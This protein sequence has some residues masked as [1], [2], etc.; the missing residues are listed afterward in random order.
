MQS[1]CL[2][3]LMFVVLVAFVNPSSHAWDDLVEFNEGTYKGELE[4]DHEEKVVRIRYKKRGSWGRSKIEGPFSIATPSQVDN[5]LDQIENFFERFVFPENVQGQILS[6]VHEFKFLGGGQCQALH[7]SLTSVDQHEA[8]SA[9]VE[10]VEKIRL[11]QNPGA[12]A[13]RSLLIQEFKVDLGKGM[14][15]TIQLRMA[16]DK[17]D[18]FL[19]FSF[20]KDQGDLAKYTWNQSE[21]KVLL[22][23]PQGQVVLELDMRS[24][25]PEGG[26]LVVR[27]PKE[28]GLE[29]VERSYFRLTQTPVKKGWEVYPYTTQHFGETVIRN[30]VALTSGTANHTPVI[31][32]NGSEVAFSRIDIQRIR[33]KFPFENLE[34]DEARALESFYNQCMGERLSFIFE[35][36]K[37]GQATDGSF[38]SEQQVICERK[39]QLETLNL[40]LQKEIVEKELKTEVKERSLEKLR[41]CLK[42]KELAF[43]EN[44]FFSYDFSKFNSLTSADFEEKKKECYSL[45]RVEVLKGRVYKSIVNN[46]LLKE[47]MGSERT[48]ELL[49]QSVSSKLDGSCFSVVKTEDLDSCLDYSKILIGENLFL[50][51]TSLHLSQ[52]YPEDRTTYGKKR[53]E[54]VQSFSSC[55]EGNETDAVTALRAGELVGERLARIRAKDIECAQ[56]ATLDLAASSSNELFTEA[57]GR[58]GLSK[59]DVASALDNKEL[60]DGAL[61]SF[62]ECLEQSISEEMELSS[63]I[64]NISFYQESCLTTG[65]RPF[66]N[67]VLSRRFDDLAQNFD[68]LGQDRDKEVLRQKAHRLIDR[69]LGSW[70]EVSQFL[71]VSESLERPFHSLVLSNHID[72]IEE[73]LDREDRREF[74]NILGTLLNDSSTRP[75]KLKLRRYFD[76]VLEKSE[77]G[78]RPQS[79]YL[80]VALNDLMKQ[81]HLKSFPIRTKRDIAS[82]VL[83]EADANSIAERVSEGTEKCWADYS[84]NRLT[85]FSQVYR[86]CEK[87]RQSKV[88]LEL[89]RRRMERHVATFFPLTSDKANKILTPVQY[90]ESCFSG[91]DPYKNKS[92]PEYEKLIEGCLRVAELDISYNISNAK[93]DSYR[94]LLS[95]R[96]YHDAV[97]AYCY[98]I[99]FHHF[100]DG[101]SK[102]PRRGDH[103]GAYRDLTKMQQ[104]QRGRLPYEG[105]L[106]RYFKPSNLFE[107]EFGENDNRQVRGLV[108]TFA[109]N[110]EFDNEWWQ[111]KL[112]HCEKGTNDF[113]NIGFREY[114]IESIPALSFSKEQNDPNQK[115]MRD[116][117]DFELVDALLSYKKAYE[118]KH[119]RNKFDLG[120]LVPSQRTLDPE[121]G[122]T[123]L[124]NFIEVLGNYM[125]KGFIFDEEAMRTELIVFQ[126]ELKSFL[127]WSADNP[128]RISITEARDFFKESKLAEHLALAAI[129]ET[130]YDKFVEGIGNMKREE[131]DKLYKEANCRYISCLNSK[132]RKARREIIEKYDELTKLCREMISDHDFRNLVYSRGDGKEEE[133]DLASYDFRRIISPES[134][135]GEEIVDAIKEKILM[136]KILGLPVS[137]LAERHV[138]SLVGDALVRDNTDGGFADRFVEQAAQFALTKEEN[139]RWGITKF[140]FFDNKDFDWDTLKKTDAGERA[141]KY[142]ARFIMMPRFLGHRQSDYLKKLRLERFRELLTEAQKENDD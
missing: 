136:P 9:L 68:F 61:V 141:I 125:S 74:L 55:R 134:E 27:H 90:L 103:P 45:S 130:T 108:E 122:V 44:D 98:N 73:S 104:T 22:R 29:N 114:V 12:E 17:D 26:L 40:L 28:T 117:L 54:I 87:E 10:E 123:A 101:D 135:K 77:R 88:A 105:S 109:A 38:D 118:Q 20:A 48:F 78:D 140:F 43:S 131:L 19:K 133:G 86:D 107:P 36:E 142:Y 14:K 95:R 4:Y 32:L 8:I 99:I 94:P 111:K 37:Q 7:F 23:N 63:L 119:G 30:G 34:S 1:K 91:V 92:V 126:S 82:E 50:A 97:T 62:Q 35:E 84:P 59:E 53:L 138:M 121:L 52:L 72:L 57:L 49:W 129:A 24:F 106:L 31:Q 139:S 75:L 120:Q 132:E 58:M 81:V 137:N 93:I 80:R 3:I 79:E 11:A 127:K 16:L 15:E 66:A 110:D 33:N 69:E 83:L 65:L 21:G 70:Q 100:S 39:A 67:M 5:S 6:R 51:Q 76:Q 128:D 2:K 89:F 46:Q 25:S 56:K 116:F 13:Y 115:L 85:A 18:Q 102:I 113:I 47:Q 112:N 42:E 96:G 41:A 60:F 124:T 71:N 64:S